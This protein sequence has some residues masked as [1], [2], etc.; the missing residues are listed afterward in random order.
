MEVV[1]KYSYRSS[2]DS[3]GEI[4]VSSCL[5]DSGDSDLHGTL[6]VTGTASLL[7][8]FVPVPGVFMGVFSD[9]QPI[10][11]NA[12]RPRIRYKCWL[13]LNYFLESRIQKY[14]K[15]GRAVEVK[16]SYEY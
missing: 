3:T 7:S 5:P 15:V 12:K 9:V 6:V 14:V 10:A 4:S 2:S 11:P 16:S 8:T 1:Q 13:I